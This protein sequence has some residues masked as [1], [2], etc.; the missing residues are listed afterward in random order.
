MIYAVDKYLDVLK[1]KQE[2]EFFGAEPKYHYFDTEDQAKHFIRER[3]LQ[4]F[5]KE[6]KKCEAARRR[7]NRVGK[8]FGALPF[9]TRELPKEKP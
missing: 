2:K 6:E 3:A 7:V 9:A 4:E 1:V 5:L 8:K